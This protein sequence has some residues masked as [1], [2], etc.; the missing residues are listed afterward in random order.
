[1]FDCVLPTR[2]ARNGTVF[3]WDGKVNIR[4]ACHTRDFGRGLSGPCGCY[5]CKNFSRAYLRHLFLAGEILSLRLL[6]LHNVYFYMDLVRQARVHILQGDFAG[7]LAQTLAR[8]GREDN[9]DSET[10]TGAHHE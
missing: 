2:N 10:T 5:T 1:M 7:F 3:S 8:L 4:N 6:T 9:G